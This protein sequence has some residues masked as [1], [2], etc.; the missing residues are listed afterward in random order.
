MSADDE[1]PWQTGSLVWLCAGAWAVP[2]GGH[3]WLGRRGKGTMLFVALTLMFAVG[4]GLEGRLF[5]FDFTEPLVGL[6][7]FANTGI[8]VPY[9]VAKAAGL[10]TGEVR[11]VTYE[12]GNAFLIVAGLLNVLVIIDACDIAL[13]R[14]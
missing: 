12:Y 11:A 4:L 1:T 10:G 6:A 2:G 9:I 13:R 14:K 5:P 3:V 7:A 8:G